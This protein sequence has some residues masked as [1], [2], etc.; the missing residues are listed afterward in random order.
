[1]QLVQFAIALAGPHQAAEI[2][3]DQWSP[4]NWAVDMSYKPIHV[5]PYKCNI[6][7]VYTYIY[8]MPTATY[9][10]SLQM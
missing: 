2:V 7:Y 9:V 3:T 8:S 10:H 4:P 1:M 5:H 6:T